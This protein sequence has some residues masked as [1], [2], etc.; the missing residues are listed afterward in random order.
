MKFALQI[1][2]Q[3]RTFQKTLPTLLNFIDY[4]NK[5]VDVFLFINK[6]STENFS[7]S[8]GSYMLGSAN[9]S[10]DN[11]NHLISLLKL[12]RIKIIKYINE[13]T[14]EEK[15]IEKTKLDE[16][17]ILWR[18]FEDK[19]GGISKHDIGPALMYRR[20]LLNNMRLD[21]EKNNNIKY[22]YVIQ[23]RFDFGTTYTKKYDINESTTPV[24][25]SDSLSIGKPEFINK[26]SEC[27]L[28]WPITPKVLY[29]DNCNLLIE[30]YEKYKNWRGEKFIEKHWIFMPELNIRLFLLEYNIDFIEA[31]WKEPCNYGFKLIR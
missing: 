2:G 20:Y 27:I 5:D 23:T 28:E 1:H 22:D 3:L 26:E 31:W 8:A 29:D 17:Q 16:Y 4:Y 13:M 12:D 6:G 18:K 14:D 10:E 25:L 19:Y 24:M 21:Y 30:K 11:M 7:Y 9:Y 15:Q